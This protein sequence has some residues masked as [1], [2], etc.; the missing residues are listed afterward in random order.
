MKQ[1]KNFTE[2]YP[3]YLSQHTN[4]TNR[5]LHFVGSTLVLLCF[6]ELFTTGSMWWLL[7]APVCGYGFAWIG[8]FFYEKN[9]PATFQHP[10]YS[11]RGDWVMYGQMWK[12]FVKE[13][14]SS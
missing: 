11:L 8:H 2:F 14:G 9:R 12:G 5:K 7:A 1:Y 3:D 10:W 4:R 13:S 6:I